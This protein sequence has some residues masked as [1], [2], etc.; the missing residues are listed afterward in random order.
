MGKIEFIDDLIIDVASED[1]LRLD[2]TCSESAKIFN[3]RG[4]NRL[5]PFLLAGSLIAVSPIAAVPIANINF[6]ENIDSCSSNIE[7]YGS[8]I[9]LPIENF[10]K[11]INANLNIGKYSKMQIVKDIISFRCL[12]NNWD[13]YNSLP[14]EVESASNAINFIDLIGDNFT[15]NLVDYY[16]NPN[17]TISFLWSNNSKESISVEIGNK[18]FSYFVEL[19]SQDPLFYNNV[20]FNAK[21]ANKLSDYIGIL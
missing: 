9:D 1:Y 7:A 20:D 17:G 15:L 13:G 11:D 14:L 12:N 4:A 18:H 19:N 3:K 16:P 8:E 10:L 5:V 6:I 2:E 21:E